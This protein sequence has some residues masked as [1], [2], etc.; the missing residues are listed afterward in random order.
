MDVDIEDMNGRVI[1]RNNNLIKGDGNYLI[2]ISQVE[3]GIYFI[4]LKT[5]GNQLIYKVQ[6]Q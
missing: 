1:Q 5:N 4:K 6:K 3:T 2:D